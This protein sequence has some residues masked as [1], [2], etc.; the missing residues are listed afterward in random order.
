MKPAVSNS[1]KGTVPDEYVDVLGLVGAA[2]KLLCFPLAGELVEVDDHL[3][4]LA[5]DEEDGD[6]DQGES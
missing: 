2:I 1:L 4:E 3:E 5:E 6:G